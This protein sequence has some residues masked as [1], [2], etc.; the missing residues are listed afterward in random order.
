MW[1]LRNTDE[2]K[3]MVWG[4]NILRKIDGPAE[5]VVLATNG[6]QE[7]IIK[8]ESVFPRDGSEWEIRWTVSEKD[9]AGK[10]PPMMSRRRWE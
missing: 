9:P 2:R 8:K 4:T 3:P 6:G 10:R 5:D 7:Q 1:P